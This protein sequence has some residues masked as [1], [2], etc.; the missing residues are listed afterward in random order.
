M[1]ILLGVS[2]IQGVRK[3]NKVAFNFCYGLQHYPDTNL[4]PI[5]GTVPFRGNVY[6]T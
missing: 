5:N 3:T 6:A 1:T 4:S 2:L